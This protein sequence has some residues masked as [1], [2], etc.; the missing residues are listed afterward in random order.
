MSCRQLRIWTNDRNLSTNDV[1]D[2]EASKQHVRRAP[3]G[4]VSSHVG[5]YLPPPAVANPAIHAD[6]YE[7]A[8]MWTTDKIKLQNEAE[9]VKQGRGSD[10][11][12]T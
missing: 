11:L 8:N 6:G 5:K 4:I 12:A 9:V 1:D 10:A 2:D 7:V 3:A